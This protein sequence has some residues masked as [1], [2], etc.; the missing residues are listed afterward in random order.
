MIIAKDIEIPSSEIQMFAIRAQG[1][2]GQN[3]NKV[4]TA[5]HLRFDIN[6]SSLPTIY[7]ERLLTLG[8]YRIT[9]AGII[10]IKAQRYRIQEKNR[11]DALDRLRELIQRVIVTRRKRTATKPTKNSQQRRLDSKAKHSLNKKFRNKNISE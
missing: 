6:S 4:S 11:S 8:D 5:I 10:I 7:K 9:S 2:G 1:S 3:V